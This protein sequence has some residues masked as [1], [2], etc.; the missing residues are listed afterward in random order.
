MWMNVNKPIEQ[1][2]VRKTVP[3]K[4]VAIN[5]VV[6]MDIFCMME[7]IK[8]SV[9]LKQKQQLSIILAMVNFFVYLLKKVSENHSFST[10]VKLFEPPP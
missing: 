2:D 10:Y 5:A 9:D 8:L 4:Q 1:S 3:M 6:R 7:I